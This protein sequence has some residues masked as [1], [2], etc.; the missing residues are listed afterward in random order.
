MSHHRSE[1]KRPGRAAVA[2]MTR[3]QRWVV[4]VLAALDAA[5]LLA[6]YALRLP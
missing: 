6:L 1:S 3:G 4:T 2:R 5:V